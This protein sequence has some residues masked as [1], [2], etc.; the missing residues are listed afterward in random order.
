MIFTPNKIKEIIWEKLS[1]KMESL[2]EDTNGVDQYVWIIETNKQKIVLKYPKNNNKIRNT[3]ETIA[4]KLLAKKDVIVPQILYMDDQILIE[5]FL[6]GT[7]V[8]QVDFSKVPRYELFFKAGEVLKKIHNIKTINFGLVTDVSL[9]GEFSTQLD[10]LQAGSSDALSSL[11]ETPFYSRKDVK[12]VIEYFESHKTVVDNSPSVL[13][14][15][16]YCDSN[17]VYTPEGEIGV[18]DFADL[19]TGNPMMDVTKVYIDHI[20]DSAFQASI[21]GYGVIQLEQVKLFALGWLTWLIPVLWKRNDSNERV[22]RLRQVYESI[23][24]WN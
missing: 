7:L 23:W 19:S 12:Q 1:L 18:I 10:Y 20:G 9:V 2:S 3:R 8:N 22:K 13:L 15:S 6:D 5:T 17:L 24:K 11:E 16:D 4:C 21:D 14:H